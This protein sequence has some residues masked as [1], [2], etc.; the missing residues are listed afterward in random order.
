MAPGRPARSIKIRVPRH[1]AQ[2]IGAKLSGEV[3]QQA[4]KQAIRVDTTQP[5]SESSAAIAQAVVR[6]TL[7]NTSSSLKQRQESASEWNSLLITARA[8][9]GPQWDVGTQVFHIDQYSELYYD[10]TPLFDAVK[11]QSD[12]EHAEERKQQ[13]QA[14]EQHAQAQQ[15]YREREQERARERELQLQNVQQMALLDQPPSPPP[16]QQYNNVN[17]GGY[18]SYPPQNISPM[19]GPYGG[20]APPFNPGPGYYNNAMGQSPS[21]MG[22]PAMDPRMGM[23]GGMGM[24][25]GHMGMPMGMNRGGMMAPPSPPRRPPRT[26]SAY[27]DAAYNPALDR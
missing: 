22:M 4:R 15:A 8:E 17:P 27:D 20:G 24:D 6:M 25:F 11:K 16:P 14:Q 3:Q 19:R 13:Q 12:V 5:N 18:G 7:Y 23:G 21:R 1:N 26:G 10:S 9:R 2:K